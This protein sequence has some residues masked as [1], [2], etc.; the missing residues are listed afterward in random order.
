MKA[1]P[2]RPAL[3]ERIIA[4]NGRLPPIRVE[5][6]RI[7]HA[8][9]NDDRTSLVTGFIILGLVVATFIVL[10]VAA[11]LIGRGL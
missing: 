11:F 9:A 1:A 7:A 6:L 4:G 8:A 5:D 10:G 3:R 2:I